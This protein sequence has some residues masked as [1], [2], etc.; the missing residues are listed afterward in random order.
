MAYDCCPRAPTPVALRCWAYCSGWL[1]GFQVTPGQNPPEQCASHLAVTDRPSVTAS[2]MLAW[3]A[4]LPPLAFPPRSTVPNTAPHGKSGRRRPCVKR[5]FI[6]RRLSSCPR[7]T[8]AGV[9]CSWRLYR[10]HTLRGPCDDAFPIHAPPEC[11][12]IGVGPHQR[13]HLWRREPFQPLREHRDQV[14]T[15]RRR[16]QP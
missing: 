12:Q 14:L 10:I 8:Q 1:Y 13:V 16:R 9:W 15:Q 2:D 4:T 11:P 7:W 3:R 6:F 5:P